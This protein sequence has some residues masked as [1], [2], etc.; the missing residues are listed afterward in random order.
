MPEGSL[1]LPTDPT[2]IDEAVAALRPSDEPLRS[3]WQAVSEAIER[4]DNDILIARAA[5]KAALHGVVLA[6]EPSDA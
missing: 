1:A 2:K 4:N 6:R 5:L 3:V